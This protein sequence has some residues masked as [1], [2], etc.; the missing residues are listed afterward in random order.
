MV[1]NNQHGNSFIS[2][3]QGWIFNL[4]SK[5]LARLNVLVEVTKK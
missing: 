5:K 4:M 1:W 2:H 3:R